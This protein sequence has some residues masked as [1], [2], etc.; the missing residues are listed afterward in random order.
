M[1]VYPVC[2]IVLN[3]VSSTVDTGLVKILKNKQNKLNVTIKYCLNIVKTFIF[4][5]MYAYVIVSV[6]VKYSET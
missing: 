6:K 1:N 5:F 2:G 4:T 3:P